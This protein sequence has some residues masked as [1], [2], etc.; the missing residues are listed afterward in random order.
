MSDFSVAVTKSQATRRPSSGTPAFAR[1]AVI[2]GMRAACLF[3]S[4]AV[5][6]PGQDAREPSGGAGVFPS[7]VFRVFRIDGVPSAVLQPLHRP[8]QERLPIILLCRLRVRPPRSA[9]R[10]RPF[11][12]EE[13]RGAPLRGARVRVRERRETGTIEPIREKATICVA[14]EKPSS[15]LRRAGSKVVPSTLTGKRAAVRSTRSLRGRR[16]VV[17]REDGASGTAGG[18]R[19]PRGAGCSPR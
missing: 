5:G 12:V 1:A 6:R 14:G 11:H 15:R 19:P 2:P 17:P 3:S 16:R 8:D 7:S 10:A 13:D 9:G 4:L 18:T